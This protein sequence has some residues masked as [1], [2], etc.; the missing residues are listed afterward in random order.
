MINA[1]Q[2]KARLRDEKDP[3]QYLDGELSV[4]I[5]RLGEL[6]G[7]IQDTISAYMGRTNKDDPFDLDTVKEELKNMGELYFEINTFSRVRTQQV[8]NRKRAD[9]LSKALDKRQRWLGQNNQDR[10]CEK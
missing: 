6:C 1:E 5:D 3:L 2:I 4:R 10:P 9:Q 7:N 8:K